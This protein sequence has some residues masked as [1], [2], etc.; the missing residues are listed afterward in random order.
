MGMTAIRARLTN[1]TDA[2]RETDVDM[3][4]DSGAIY[5]V[6]PSSILE[7]LGVAPE[8][9]QTFW[10]ADGRRVK[11]RVGHVRFEIQ[12]STGISKVIFGRVGDASLLGVLTLEALGLSLDPLRRT[13][14][15][16]KLMIA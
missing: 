12:G 4:V 8:S 16:L 7:Q 13:L 15:P 5:S 10:L 1:V 11:R 2:R 6:V 14:R 3:T 9:T